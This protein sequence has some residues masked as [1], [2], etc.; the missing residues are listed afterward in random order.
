MATAGT[1]PKAGPAPR[2]MGAVR[3]PEDRGAADR[4]LGLTARG[5]ADAF[6]Q[7]YD[8]TAPRLFAVTTRVLGPGADAE[9]ALQEA[10]VKAWRH[11]GGWPGER[12]T[13]L[14]WLLSVARHAAIDRR[15]ARTRRTRHLDGVAREGLI[16]PVAARGPEQSPEDA[17]ALSSEADQLAACMDA[18]PAERAEVI[19]KA[20]FAGD[21]YAEMAEDTGRPEG[22]LKSWVH[23]SLAALRRCLEARGVEGRS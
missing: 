22:T 4:L 10:F 17:A 21:S 8:E 19:R 5:D 2:G 15:R 20:Y 1:A 13:A 16:M 23:R 3:A 12:G 18:L 7:L 9:E 14:P 6:G 11:A